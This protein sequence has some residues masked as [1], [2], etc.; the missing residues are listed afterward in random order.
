MSGGVSKTIVGPRTSRWTAARVE[1]AGEPRRQLRNPFRWGKA[2]TGRSAGLLAM[3][4]MTCQCLNRWFGPFNSR[5]VRGRR[6]RLLRAWGFYGA[7][8]FEPGV[9]P[10][11]LSSGS[12]VFPSWV[13]A[14][15]KHLLVEMVGARSDEI[16]C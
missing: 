5:A 7:G 9:S 2:N 6:R 16:I 12:F 15:L 10:P 3:P 13:S 8:F 4:A 1:P 11:G 14:G